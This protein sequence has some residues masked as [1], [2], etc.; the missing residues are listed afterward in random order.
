MSNA[1]SFGASSGHSTV[2]NR[3]ETSK[4]GS[5]IER[6]NEDNS[7]DI[8]AQFEEIEEVKGEISEKGEIEEVKWEISDNSSE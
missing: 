2:F 6:K 8:G 5:Q 4:D 7:S 1:S 3:M